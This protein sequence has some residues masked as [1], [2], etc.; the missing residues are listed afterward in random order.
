MNNRKSGM[1]T[2]PRGLLPAVAGWTFRHRNSIS[3]TICPLDSGFPRRRKRLSLAFENHSELFRKSSA[4]PFLRKGMYL[5]YFR[6]FPGLRLG[7]VTD[8]RPHGGS[9]NFYLVIAMHLRVRV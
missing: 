4:T 2:L 5:I 1:R 8:C 7:E 9:A 6:D 3:G